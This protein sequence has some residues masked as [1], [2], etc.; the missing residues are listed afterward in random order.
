MLSRSQF[1]LILLTLG[2][3]VLFSNWGRVADRLEARLQQEAWRPRKVVYWTSSGSPEADLYRARLFM[4]AHPDVQVRPNFRE[5]GGLQDMLFLSFLS[6]NPPDFLSAQSH[7]LRGYA[8]FGGIRPMDDLLAQEGPDYFDQFLDGEGRIHRFQ[9]NPDDLMF[10]RD[11]RGRFR[12]PEEAA[13]LL[14]L[15][16]SVVGLRTVSMP[17]TLTYNKRIF[18]EAAAMF[19]EAGLVDELGEP[20][21]P[22]TW[23]ELYETARVISEYGR[24]TAEAR[25]E[26][27]P[28]TFG[29]VI[30]GE[31]SRD[32]M[33]GIR[34]LARRAGS[35]NFSFQGDTDVVQR[36]FD[37]TRPGGQRALAR[38]AGQPVGHFEYDHPSQMAAFAL[39]LRMQRDGMIL[40][41][42]E[43]RHYEDV[44]TA[45][46]TGQAAMLLD[47]WHAALI[48][49][50]R[51]PWAAA[52]LGSAPIPIPYP[53]EADAAFSEAEIARH[54]EAVTALLELDVLGIDLPPG[55]PL[56]RASG[57][58]VEFLTS[59]CRDPQAAWDWLHFGFESVEL[60]QAS[61]RR[62]TLPLVRKALEHLEDP[63]WF[64]FAYQPQVY[65]IITDHTEL[66]PSPPQHGPVGGFSEQEIF[67]RRFF[68]DDARPL[69]E[70]LRETREELQGFN[71]AANR[72]LARRIEDGITRPSAWTF[73]EFSPQRAQVA[74]EQQQAQALQPELKEA[75]AALEAELVAQARGDAR[76]HH[77]LEADQ[78]TLRADLWQFRSRTHPLKI[79]W[80]PATLAAAVLLWLLVHVIRYRRAPRDWW[81]RT[82]GAARESW[83]AYLFVLP[84]MLLLFTF[85][86]YPSLTQFSLAMQRGDGLSAMQPVGWDNYA[87]ILNPNHPQFDR[88]FWTR[89]LPNT[90]KFMAGVTAG[91]VGFGLLLASLLNLPLRANR[92]YRVLFFVPLVTSLAVVSVIFIGLLKG[93]DS[94]VNQFLLSMGWEQLPY[95]LGLTDT[96]GRMINWLGEQAGLATV[97]FVA[98][99]HGLP[100]NIILL[101]AGLQSIS[102]ELYEAAR[103]DGAGSWA[104]FRHVTL[105]ELSPILAIITFQA[106]LGAARAFSV[107]FVLTEGGVNH[108]SELVATYIFKWGFM[109]PD[110]RDADLGYASALGVVYAVLLALLTLTNVWIIVRR[111]RQRLAMEHQAAGGADA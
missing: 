22:R 65:R 52:D 49:T 97:M 77:L 87:R 68:Q 86:I 93:E 38:Y 23:W 31:R 30:Q 45:L 56:P 67:Y 43:S 111:W 58:Q 13:R 55:N 108:S 92:V 40:P 29:L 82:C 7:E 57:E 107:V 62:G 81:Q 103:V 91:Q 79:L 104:R 96:P 42:V 33:R 10:S 5:S 61:T 15:S 28:V 39:L 14:R 9:V 11:E 37:A 2:V 72:D 102:P 17:D 8:L 69:A 12:H 36:H 83:P 59:L 90:L 74:F 75:L 71:E 44:R 89:V 98:V 110:G 70:I 25:G 3:A 80:V 60:L 24:R 53:A 27:T 84:G 73:P 54:R 4:D 85:A 32:L 63:D 16:G 94:G 50:E 95:R 1:S 35:V 101:L 41:G 26:R 105:P 34:P 46:A 48:G 18:R 88:I 109:K 99:W 19:P 47:G 76:L 66:W 78:Q 64:P 100:Y 21:P 6:G 51:V 106:F 20:V